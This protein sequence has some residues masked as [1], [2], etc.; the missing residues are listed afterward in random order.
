MEAK[1]LHSILYGTATIDLSAVEQLVDTSQT[2]A[3]AYILRWM[4]KVGADGKK[5]LAEL[6][7]EVFA[8]SPKRGWTPSPRSL[9][10]TLATWPCRGASRWPQR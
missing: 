10:S 6:L 2:R 1:G 9:A 3:I 5:T 7:D 4:D 8:S